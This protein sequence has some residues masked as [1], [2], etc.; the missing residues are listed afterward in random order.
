VQSEL[1]TLHKATNTMY[2]S[3]YFLAIAYAGLGDKDRGFEWM[4]TAYRERAAWLTFLKVDPALDPLRSDPRFA[5]LLR[6]IGLPHSDVP[7]H[8]GGPDL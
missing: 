3:P 2:V 7:A 4:E 6:R 5:D 1:E 8:T